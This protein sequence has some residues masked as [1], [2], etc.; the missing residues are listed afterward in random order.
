V[1]RKSLLFSTLLFATA[2]SVLAGPIDDVVSQVSQANYTNTLN[3]SLYT[4][5]GDDR[6]LAGTEHDLAQA[7]IFNAFQSYG[8]NPVLEPFLHISTTY[9]NVVA[10]LPG[11]VNPSQIYVVGAH[12]DSVGNP[13]ADD[14]ASGVAGVIEAA[15]VLSQ[16]QFAS[17]IKFIAFDREEQG[18]IGSLN[19]TNQHNTDNVL[20]MVQLDMIAYNP[21]PNQDMAYLYWA[22]TY[23]A[24]FLADLGAAMLAYGGIQTTVGNNGQ[25]DH[26]PFGGHGD[27]NALVIEY[28][29]WTNPYYHQQTDSVD[30]PSYIDYAYATNMTKGVVGYVATAAELLQQTEIPE[31]CS[32]MLLTVSAIALVRRKRRLA[33]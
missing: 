30:T 15:R 7:N 3:N 5:T 24:A 22:N 16:H 2:I 25:S 26:A 1:L 8:L 6:G 28:N 9:Y 10:T 18:L 33:A 14:D 21:P 19:Y 29:V 17:T 11:T 31:P 23:D 32:A 27:S 12:Y 13:G 20:G 4:H